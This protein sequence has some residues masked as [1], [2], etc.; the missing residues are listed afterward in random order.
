MKLHEWIS[1]A[2]RRLKASSS[3]FGDPFEHAGQIVQETLQWTAAQRVSEGERELASEQLEPLERFLSRRL[4]GEPFQYISGKGGFWKALFEVGPG[5]LIPRPETEILVEWLSQRPKSSQRVAELG[6]G[7]GNIGISVLG[8]QPNWL[9]WAFEKSPSAVAFADRNATSILGSERA[10]YHLV[11]G[12]FFEQAS[13]GAPW[14]Y[15][16]S[17]PPYVKHAEI[18]ALAPEIQH[19]PVEALDGGETGLDVIERLARC[20]ASWIRPG[21]YLVCEIG[22]EQEQE[23]VAV[24]QGLGY[25]GVEC[26]R[27]LA[28]KPRVLIGRR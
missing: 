5:V 17:N 18:R 13:E 24:L 26:L 6:A 3:S 10:R 27:D 2:A 14:D 21:G 20:G 4:A 12:D 19:E 28:S 15:I 8:E 22:S 25:V 16:V 1:Q 23:A 11:P 9:W 7:S